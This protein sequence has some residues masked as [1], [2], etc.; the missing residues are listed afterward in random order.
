MTNPYDQIRAD[1]TAAQADDAA[2]AADDAAQRQQVAALTAEVAALEAEINPTPPPPPPPPTGLPIPGINATSATEHATQVQVWS[3]KAPWA[4]RYYL[5]PGEALHL[6]T[7][8]TVGPTEQLIISAP[9]T[10]TPFT[11]A[12]LVAFFEQFPTDRDWFFVLAHENDAK[13]RKGLYT[14]DQYRTACHT[15]RLAQQQVG[16]PHIKLIC[17]L[18]GYAWHFTVEDYLPADADYDILT[19]DTYFNGGPGQIGADISTAS[20]QFDAQVATAKK[21]GKPW[22][23]TETGVGHGLSGQ[24]KLDAVTLLA[25]TIKA[26]GAYFSLLFNF[27]LTTDSWWL[28]PAGVAAWKAGQTG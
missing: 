3:P 5:Q 26:H 16:N 18:T 23:I 17:C 20:A 28:D 9:L 11:Q 25:K 19:S 6:P 21:H 22:G 14:A 10:S 8:Y 1:V 13:I 12:Q 27:G 24:A 7:E 15:V 2:L 4:W